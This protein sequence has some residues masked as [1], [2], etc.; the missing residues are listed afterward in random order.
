M[1]LF[2]SYGT[3][4]VADKKSSEDKLAT[5]ILNSTVKFYGDWYEVGLLWN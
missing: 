4:M 3:S 1:V 2:E 5:E